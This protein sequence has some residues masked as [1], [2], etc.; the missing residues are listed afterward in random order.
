[1]ITSKPENIPS[2]ATLAHWEKHF[3]PLERVTKPALTTAEYAHY[4]GM[5]EQTARLH[6]CKDKGPVRPIRL[7]GCS[8]LR[9]PTS[10]VKALLLGVAA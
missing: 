4:M 2:A 5:T 3:P 1:V 7:P 8:L 9:W 6:A 10:A